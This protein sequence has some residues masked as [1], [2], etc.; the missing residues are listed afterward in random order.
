M[1]SRIPSANIVD[2]VQI[3]NVGDIAYK[4]AD[5]SIK[6]VNPDEWSTSLGTPVGVVVIPSGFAPDNGLA[7]IV[8]LK[9]GSSSV[10][11]SD[12]V[13]TSRWSDRTVDTPL[14]N[15][16]AVTITNNTGGALPSNTYGYLPS[17]RF[18]G[19]V[20][21]TDP[22][23]KYSGSSYYIPSPYLGSKP[24]PAYYDSP[25]SNMLSDF[26]GK[27]NTNHLKGSVGGVYQAAKNA[28]GYKSA[29][30]EEIVWYLP[31]MGELG[32]LMVRYNK[33]NAALTKLGASQLAPDTYY[34]SSTEFMG[35]YACAMVP[36]GGSVGSDLVTN[37]RAVRPFAMLD[38]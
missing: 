13:Y 29:G 27:D 30:A 17:D 10:T 38:F 18:A 28:W 19:T 1:D 3:A 36:T 8:S 37:N 16:S 2:G 24:N 14:K 7:R 25:S 32:Y 33:I 11:G 22:E 6:V 23:A 31:A 5:G 21:Y 12:K 15:Y 35:G 34:W 4:A 26:N 9:W 20:S